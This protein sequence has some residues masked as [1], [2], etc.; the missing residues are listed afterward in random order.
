[1][2]LLDLFT[3]LFIYSSYS[4]LNHYSYILFSVNCNILFTVFLTVCFQFRLY[5][6]DTNLAFLSI[7]LFFFS[8][9]ILSSS[10]HFSPLSVV[11]YLNIVNLLTFFQKKR[12]SAVISLSE[13][14]LFICLTF[15]VSMAKFA[16]GLCFSSASSHL[17][18]TFIYIPQYILLIISDY[19]VSS[20][21]I[22]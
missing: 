18:P 19:D 20:N 16:F 10:I 3:C 5:V 4:I 9:C 21:G 6:S 14:K 12:F 7:V 8:F 13:Y 2:N 1:M 17:S 22:A 11:S 15:Q